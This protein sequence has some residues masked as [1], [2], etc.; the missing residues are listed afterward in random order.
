MFNKYLML[1]F[2]IIIKTNCVILHIRSYTLSDRFEDPMVDFKLTE[3]LPDSLRK[4]KVN[5]PFQN[6]QSYLILIVN[7]VVYTSSLIT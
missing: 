2:E 1:M 7:C 5:Q 4:L 3:E 6:T